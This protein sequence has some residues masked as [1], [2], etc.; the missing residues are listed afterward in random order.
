MTERQTYWFIVALGIS[1]AWQTYSN[2]T[3]FVA[4]RAI[5]A[6][7]SRAVEIAKEALK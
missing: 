5:I 7:P 2:F 4:F 3:H 1:L 6:D